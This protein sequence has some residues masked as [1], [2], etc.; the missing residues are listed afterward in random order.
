MEVLLK[1]A[2]PQQTSRSCEQFACEWL[3]YYSNW[4]LQWKFQGMLCM[5]MSKNHIIKFRVQLPFKGWIHEDKISIVWELRSCMNCLKRG[6][7]AEKCHAPQMCKRST[8]FHH[9]LLHRDV[10]QTQM[11]PEIKKG[12][13]ESHVSALSFSEQVLLM[14]CKWRSLYL[15]D[16]AR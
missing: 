10:D 16:L 7:L 2:N 4:N 15:M 1:M 12:N 14:T 6:H 8:K 13:D 11:W 5:K 3:I 9:P